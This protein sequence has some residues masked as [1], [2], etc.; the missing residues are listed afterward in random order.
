MRKDRAATLGWGLLGGFVFFWDL[1]ADIFGFEMLTTGFRRWLE[2][3]RKRIGLGLAWLFTTKHLFFGTV[4][5]WLDPF[6][7]LGLTFRL[8]HRRQHA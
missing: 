5:P 6:H 3:P 7:L 4:L 8:F 2:H 1:F